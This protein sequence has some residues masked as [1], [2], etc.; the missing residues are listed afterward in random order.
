MPA[1]LRDY[2]RPGDPTSSPL[3]CVTK[4]RYLTRLSVD[5]YPG[6]PGFGEAQWIASED[7]NVEHLLDVFTS[8]DVNALNIWDACIHF[9]EHLYWQKPR[10]TILRSKIEGLPNSHPSKSKCL[11]ELAQLIGSVGNYTE[12]KRLLAR[13]L[14]LDRGRGDESQV[15]QTLRLLSQ[16]NQH[17][18]L[19]GEGIPQVKEALEIF[20]RRRNTAGQAN[21]L[22]SLAW[23]F[24]I[25]KQ[26]DAA[27]DAALQKIDLLPEEGEEFRTCQSHRLLGNIYRSKGEKAKAIF[28]FKVALKIA[29]PFD[30]HRE[31]FWIYEAMAVLFYDNGDLDNANVHVEQAKLHTA[32][33][34]YKLGRGMQMQVQIWYRQCR[35][36]DARSEALDALEI[37]ERLGAAEGIEHC[38]ALLQ[39]FGEGLGNQTP[40]KSDS[41]ELSSRDT[42]SSSF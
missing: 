42:A 27:E 19:P 37:Y 4:D 29:S 38:R 33:N 9:L 5:L 1:P 2:L 7:I 41:R 25:D 13:T 39:K 28:H 22:G 14:T 11:F 6:K 12:E 26:L 31:L 24:L 34:A 16:V 8:I 35:L 20:K 23:L 17:F 32:D 10:H 21:C 40:E 36:D 18:G 30:W 3:L 15:A